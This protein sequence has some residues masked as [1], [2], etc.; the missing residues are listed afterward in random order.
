MKFLILLHVT[1]F[2]ETRFSGHGFAA[3]AMRMPQIE[4]HKI[5]N[6]RMKVEKRSVAILL[7]GSSRSNL[8]LW[9]KVGKNCVAILL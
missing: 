3:S 9:I 8:N 5:T 4:V 6:L 1:F 2:L 7:Q